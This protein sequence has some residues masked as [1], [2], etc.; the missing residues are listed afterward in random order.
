MRVATYLVLFAT[1]SM[2][3]CRGTANLKGVRVVKGEVESLVTTTSSG[4]VD[5]E[6]QAVLGF[7]VSGRVAGIFVK[8]A[9]RVTAGQKIA[10]LENSDF[11][12][13][14]EQASNELQRARQLFADN[15]IS[16]VA[17]DDARRATEVARANYDKTVIKAPFDGI[18]TEMNL[19]LGELAGPTSAKLGVRLVDLKPRLVRGEIDEVDLGKV[20]V[21]QIARV[22]I[23]AARSQTFQAEVTRVVPY[24]DTRKEQDRTSQ[25]ELRLKD[26][27]ELVPVG[28]SAEIEIVVKVKRGV[29]AIPSRALLGTGDKRYVYRYDSQRLVKAPI[30][31]GLSNYDRAEVVTGLNLGDTIVFPSDEV[32]L[33]DGL[34]AKVEIVPWPSSK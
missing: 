3:A 26:A 4:T 7:G 34:K 15:L 16:R 21:G 2:V 32:E 13:T 20:K 18:V 23:P 25:V 12:I 9:D 31:V 22:R 19:Q 17:F 1:L 24:V 29:L 10:Q 14:F 30:T 27:G 11:R 8:L 6:Q 33:H 28:A 5:A